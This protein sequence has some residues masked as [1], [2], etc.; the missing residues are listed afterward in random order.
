MVEVV[1]G[2]RDI[3]RDPQVASTRK[4]T[5]YEYLCT[6]R[7][8]RP[9]EG[10]VRWVTPFTMAPLLAWF[11]T[12]EVRCRPIGF[13]DPN[14]QLTLLLDVPIESY[15]AFA[16]S[17]NDDGDQSSWGI[18]VFTSD[19]LRRASWRTKAFRELG[20]LGV[21]D[22][23][24]S[25]WVMAVGIAR[26]RDLPHHLP[27]YL[28][29]QHSVPAEEA[30]ESCVTFGLGVYW[31][32]LMYWLAQEHTFGLGLPSSEPSRQGSVAICTQRGRLA[33]ILPAQPVKGDHEDDAVSLNGPWPGEEWR[34]HVRDLTQRR[35]ID[36]WRSGMAVTEISNELGYTDKSVYTLVSKLRGQLGEH[37]VPYRR[38]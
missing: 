14:V 33:G 18:R 1:S 3:Q 20:V 21:L 27:S 23:L 22:Y 10:L 28:L 5:A 15:L 17:A 31:R 8:T 12:S 6:W 34:S 19:G 24:V 35:L 36:M 37:A 32:M 30:W 7:R 13:V 29:R 38:R 2:S 25:D 9:V 11:D 16:V 4:R 26:S